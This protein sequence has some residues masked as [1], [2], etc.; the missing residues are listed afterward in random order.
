M[1]AATLTHQDETATM[2]PHERVAIVGL[3]AIFPRAD[4]PGQFWEIIEQGLATAR[5]VP[6]GR[7]PLDPTDAFD[8]RV[9]TPDRVYSTRGCFVEGFRL[10][11]EGLDLDPALLGRLD[12]MFHLALHAARAAWRD[13]R[14]D[15]VDRS[16]VGVVFGNLV[17]PTEATSAYAW[18]TLGRTFAERLGIAEE[19]T[20]PVDPWNT[21]AAGLP[22]GLVAKALGLGGG[23]FTVDAACASSLYALKLAADELLA[24]RADA[25]VTGGLSRPD[26]MYTQMGFS[27]LRALSASGVA[28]PFGAD[29]DGLVVGEGAGM[30]VLK[31]LSDAVRHGDRIHGVIAS[32]GLSNDV[33]GGLLAPQ[34]EGQVRAMRTAYAQSGWTPADV[35]LIECHATGTPVGDAVEFASL[36]TLWG[37][38][39]KIQGRCVLGSVKSNIG[40]ALTAAGAAGLLKVLLAFRHATLPP[41][42]GFDRPAPGVGLDGSPFRILARSE[43]WPRRDATTPRR[44]AISGFGFGGINAHALIEEWLPGSDVGTAEIPDEP[45]PVAIIGIAAHLGPFAGLEAV[46]HRLLGGR[47][48]GE[49]EGPRGWWGAEESGW[50]R[51]EERVDQIRPAYRVDG[52]TVAT[53]RFRIPP[54][55]IEEMLPQQA[56]LLHV[57]ADAI[58]DAGWDDQPRPRVGAFVGVGLDPNATNFHVRWSIAAKAE[59]WARALGLD[60]D[61]HATMAD[62]VKSLRDAAGPALTAN[63]TMGALGSVVASRVA[64]EFHL[65]GPSF[66]ISA[67][68]VSGLRAVD[69]AVRLLRLGELDAA[70]VGTVDLPGDLRATLTDARLRP[71]GDAPLGEGAAVVVLKRLAD[72]ERDGDRIHAV[73]RGIGAATTTET[74]ADPSIARA[75]AE[76]GVEP[77]SIGLV[78]ANEPGRS[79]DLE[80]F[81]LERDVTPG[82]KGTD[83][84]L[85]CASVPFFPAPLGRNPQ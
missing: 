14:T 46:T 5:D 36:Q 23:A 44:A 38:G 16:R 3:G 11:P 31:R 43:P 33:D 34:S 47:A 28:S 29:A 75:L 48:S 84:P 25:M 6:P 71:D 9:G 67:E 78:A 15:A 60:P 17:L 51:A 49:P 63:R 74:G 4:D 24:G 85:R 55:E 26:P 53:G 7:W 83:P 39:D 10:D 66:T 40:H 69:V 2:R 13:A 54:L 65:G 70:V 45:A 58:A 30:F 12:P 68:E 81:S 73:I 8:P 59:G 35:D 52:A 72:A 79:D 76:A 64:R 82:K 21:R 62:W 61:D 19:P 22:A 56:L 1:T 18:E 37:E 20:D 41:T 50:F 80:Q 27:Q 42:A 32:V 57:A 77:G